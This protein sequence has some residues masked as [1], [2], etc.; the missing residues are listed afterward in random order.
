MGEL[1]TQLNILSKDSHWDAMAALIP[2]ELLDAV[3]VVCP[4]DEMA[5]RIRA[6][7]EGVFDRVNLVARYTPDENGWV[8]VVQALKRLS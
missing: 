4:R 2:D 7:C 8:D 6:R 1:Q 5:A 3:A